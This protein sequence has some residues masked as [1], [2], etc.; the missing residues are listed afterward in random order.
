MTEELDRSIE[1]ALGTDLNAGWDLW[2]T[3]SMTT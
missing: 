1:F 3:T 2:Q